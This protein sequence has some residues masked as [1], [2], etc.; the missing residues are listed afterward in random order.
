INVGENMINIGL[1][2]FKNYTLHFLQSKISTFNYDLISLDLSISKKIVLHGKRLA[3]Q[4]TLFTAEKCLPNSTTELR[5]M[6]LNVAISSE[7]YF[8]YKS[9]QG[10]N[11]H[12]PWE[13]PKNAK[14]N[15]LESSFKNRF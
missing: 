15:K 3:T 8:R 12:R 13:L 10:M 2:K 5:S 4:A 14:G 7:L 9:T 11:R 1:Y 6:V